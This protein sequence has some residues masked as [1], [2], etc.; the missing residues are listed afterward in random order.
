MLCRAGC[1]PVLNEDQ[2][3]GEIDGYVVFSRV[4]DPV[5]ASFEKFGRSPVRMNRSVS[6]GSWPSKPTTISRLTSA[7]GGFWLRAI[8]HS[9]RKTHANIEAIA[10]KIVVNTTRNDERT[11]NPAPG[12]MY[13]SARAGRMTM[14]SI[15][16]M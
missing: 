14:S 3:A 5:S 6:F 13:A 16:P 2:G 7:R 4:Y 11:A 8:R 1:T 12:P 15:A 9:V 10:I